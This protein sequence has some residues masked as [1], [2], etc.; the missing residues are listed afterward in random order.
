[1]ASRISGR[2]DRMGLLP[3]RLV[4]SAPDLE[5]ARQFHGQKLGLNPAG[6]CAAFSGPFGTVHELL[7]PA[8]T[9]VSGICR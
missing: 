7:E 8:A 1:M 6:E 3:G 5:K 2:N 4:M 9:S